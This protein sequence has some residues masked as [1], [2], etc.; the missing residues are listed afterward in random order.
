MLR[1]L[2][3]SIKD[4]RG[5]VALEFA[6]LVPMMVLILAGMYQ[7]SQVVRVTMKLSNVAVAIADLVAQQDSVTGGVTGSLGNFCKAAQLMMA[8]FPTGTTTGPFSL[9]IASVTNYSASNV[10]VDWTVNAACA[11]TATGTGALGSSTTTL[12]TS[13]VNLLP[14]TGPSGTT[15]IAG[16]T[17]IVVQA[18]YKYLSLVQLLAPAAG[19]LSRMG[20]AR[21]RGNS[22]VSCTAACL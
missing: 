9:S 4:A 16:D 15:N 18:N 20:F 12:V 22:V 17:V 6:I 10:K 14:N 1:R 5:V 19:S 21:P 11:T 7:V 3:A 2:L 8:P 13:P